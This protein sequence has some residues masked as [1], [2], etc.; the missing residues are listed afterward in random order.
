MKKFVLTFPNGVTEATMAPTLAKAKSN[1]AW[2]LRR[3]GVY[4]PV[5]RRWAEGAKEA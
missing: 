4:D 5:A 2:R 3:L 1:F